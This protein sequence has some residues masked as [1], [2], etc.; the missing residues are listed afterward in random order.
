M[1]LLKKIDLF[2]DRP[3]SQMEKTLHIFDMDDTILETP[4]FGM[5]VGVDHNQVVDISAHF[6][7]YFEKVKAVIMQVL[8][9]DVYFKRM[10]DF[11]VP[12]SSLTDQPFDQN[13]FHYFSDT[14][15]QKMFEVRNDILVLRT[16]QGFHRDPDTIGLIVNEPIFSIYESV[17]NK[18]I[19]TG[20]DEELRSKI[21]YIF[22]FIGMPFPNYG[23]KLF[24]P[25][26]SKN[27][28]QFKINSILD[29]IKEFGWTEIHFYE[30]RK[31]WL[32]NAMAA[33]KAT[34]PDVIFHP[35]L[36]TNIKEKMKLL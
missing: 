28:E 15:F 29:S 1:K 10:H 13:A 7:Q 14:E 26:R 35:H 33:C 24:R 21:M 23:L 8:L 19:L 18:M 27:I 6:P 32:E 5:F 34:Y 20:R 9:K 36:I 25:S 16:F 2:K 11:I 17:S 4:T 3:L 12:I 30:D 31:D 22:N